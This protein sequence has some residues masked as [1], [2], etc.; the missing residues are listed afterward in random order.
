M[1]NQMKICEEQ[2]GFRRHFST[3]DHIYTLY[4][5][6]NNRLYGNKRGKL[7]V[8]FIDYKKAF[9][10]VNRDILWHILKEQGVSTKMI[11][12][13]KAIYSTV[14]AT[15]RFGNKFSEMIDCPLGVKQ[16]CLLSPLLFS[17]LINKVAQK[18]A[19][20]GR[21]GYQFIP[22]GKEIFSL[23]FADDIV[24][25]SQT[26]SGLQNQI[27]N[28]KIASEEL[29]LEI[30][31]Q[32]T[33]S[34]VF[35]KGGYLGRAEKWYYGG[36]QIE[37]VNSYKYLGYTFTTKLSTEIALSEFAGRAKGKIISIFKALYK[38]GRIDISIFFHLFDA[39]VKPMALYAA[40]VWGNS[41]N[42]AMN[43]IEKVHMFAARKLLGVSIK[44]PKQFIY[45]ELNRYP[46]MIDSKIKTLK[47]WL[48]I[49]LMEDSRIPKQAY[50]RDEN[51]LLIHENSW[52]GAIKKMLETNGYGYIWINKGTQMIPSFIR[53]FKQRLIDQFWQNWSDKINNK[54]RFQIYRE[55]KTQHQR[56]DYLKHITVTKFRKIF[57]KMRFGVLDINGNKRYYDENA[58]KKC[59]LCG[60][61]EENE[62][63]VFLSCPSYAMFRENVYKHWPNT[64]ELQLKE[65]L[66]NSNEDKNKDLA[67]FLFYSMKRREYLLNG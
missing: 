37:T 66:N 4:S 8:V 64:E 57:T 17:I 65:I 23:L 22:G 3:I 61:K 36:E 29:G 2:A 54:N 43:V 44:T 52:S 63:H 39:Q 18:V 56:E 62:I 31:I 38:I 16:G 10:R 15:V 30:N 19:E 42:E 25:I 13:I 51:E 33:K 40:E 59:Q 32:K 41:E 24:L 5:M 47:Y 48:K 26:P 14:K 35:R 60:Y 46:L 50:T 28:L 67:M 20:R 7:Y 9:D 21:S 53:S 11:K 58:N 34:V 55:I 45:G 27:N 49:Q 12:I 6:V 1:E